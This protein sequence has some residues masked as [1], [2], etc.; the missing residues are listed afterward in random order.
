LDNYQDYCV[1][2][3][4]TAVFTGWASSNASA[5][6]RGGKAHLK[7]SALLS[8]AKVLSQRLISS[9]EMMDKA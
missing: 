2:A 6:Q 5:Y 7:M 1:A 8:L 9:S 3:F 4:K